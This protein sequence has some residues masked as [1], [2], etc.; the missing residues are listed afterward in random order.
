M[1]ERKRNEVF[2]FFWFVVSILTFLALFSYRPED[3]PFE[4][5]VPNSPTHNFVGIAGATSHGR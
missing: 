3:I 4:V 5:S 2:A 1:D